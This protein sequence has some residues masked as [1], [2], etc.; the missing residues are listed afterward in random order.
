MT[1]AINTTESVEAAL[2]AK[3]VQPVPSVIAAEAVPA[4]GS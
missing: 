2:A 4:V 3:H 1:L